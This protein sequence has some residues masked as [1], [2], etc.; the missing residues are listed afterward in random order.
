MLYMVGSYAGRHIGWFNTFGFARINASEDFT[1]P[2]KWEYLTPT[3]GWVDT[4]VGDLPVVLMGSN[5]EPALVYNGKWQRWMLIYRGI[6]GG[7][8]FRDADSIDG[9]WSAEKLLVKDSE[10]A[11]FYAPSVLD[12]TSDGDIILLASAL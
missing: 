1:D 2:T 4:E 8:V 12:V 3:A 10:T 7:L 6:L 9:D 5:G 11:R